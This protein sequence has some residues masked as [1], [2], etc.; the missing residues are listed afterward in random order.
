MLGLVFRFSPIRS[1]L[2]NFS[3]TRSCF[4]SVLVPDLVFQVFS[5]Q[6]LFFK[7]SRTRSCFSS[8]LV[9]DLVFK[10]SRT[11]FCFQVVSHQVLCSSF[12]IP[13]FVFKF[14]NTRSFRVNVV[15][16]AK[17]VTIYLT[18]WLS[19]SVGIAVTAGDRMITWHRQYLVAILQSEWSTIKAVLMRNTCS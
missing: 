8:F 5:Y 1:C 16:V 11:M 13:G 10:F 19:C 4:S 18:S 7:F 15:G 6:V 14:S 17:L 9:P 12:L 3:R 2:L